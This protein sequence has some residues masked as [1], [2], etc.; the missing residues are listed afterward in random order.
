MT[1]LNALSMTGSMTG[2]LIVADEAEAAKAVQAD[3]VAR[4]I[5][6]SLRRHYPG[7]NWYVD[8]NMDGG[9]AT[10]KC[11][12]ISMDWGYVLHLTNTNYELAEKAK[13]AGG[14]ILE[15]FRLSRDWRGS[16]DILNIERDVRGY[17][18]GVEN[19]GE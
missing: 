10:V 4:T 16:A 12:D 2:K 13:T 17:A 14:E 7:R 3:N 19:G 8:V 6:A 1:K 11:C 5:G 18:V 9:I 15:R